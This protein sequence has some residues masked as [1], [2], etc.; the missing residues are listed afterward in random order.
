MKKILFIFFLIFGFFYTF[1][2]TY[3]H[4]KNRRECIMFTNS[5]NVNTLKCEKSDIDN[6]EF[7]YENNS[8]GINTLTMKQKSKDVYAGEVKKLGNFQIGNYIY[9]KS[10]YYDGENNTPIYIFIEMNGKRMIM[11]FA[12]DDILE[13]Y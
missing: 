9:K 10:L 1:S 4:F 5:F 6:Y 8:S 2:Q 3:Y 12:D 11:H 13:F 7:V